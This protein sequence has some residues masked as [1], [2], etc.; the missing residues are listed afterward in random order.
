MWQ[1]TLLNQFHDILPGTTISMVVGD[2]LDIYKR[3]SEQA[4]SL[5]EAVLSVLSSKQSQPAIVDP[6][7]LKRSEVY[8]DQGKLS[9]L[10]SDDNGIGGLSTPNVD[11]QNRPRAYQSGKDWVLQNQNFKLTISSGR[12]SSLVDLVAD[13]ELILP[14][15]GADD[16]G[17]MVYEDYPLAYDAWDV[18]IYHL[19]SFLSLKFEEVEAVEDDLRASL[20]A[21]ARIGK[22]TAKLTVSC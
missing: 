15:P 6:L 3:R 18:E 10:Q 17:L 9:W 20:V 14:G 11:V 13:R 1:D 8:S 22:S 19:D 4:R 12:I 21:T 16:G 5:I 7:R 2:V